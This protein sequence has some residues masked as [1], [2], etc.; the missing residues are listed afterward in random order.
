MKK[1]NQ[2]KDSETLA[3]IGIIGAGVM[4]VITVIIQMI[5]G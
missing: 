1:P 4:I 2:I 5:Y 3:S